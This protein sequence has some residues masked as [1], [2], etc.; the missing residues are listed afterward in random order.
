[1]QIYF[2]YQMYLEAVKKDY[3]ENKD[4][5][6]NRAIIEG[7]RNS[8]AHGD[9]TIENCHGTKYV[10][11]TILKFTN[12]H[13]NQVLFQASVN[14]YNLEGLFEI[15]NTSILSDFFDEKMGKKTKVK[16]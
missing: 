14:L 8:I 5:F 9:V 4:Y 2:E 12:K 13:N 6:Y 11:D 3:E 7:I 15:Q 1:M 16:K 10:G